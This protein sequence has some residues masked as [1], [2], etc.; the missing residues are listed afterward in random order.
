MRIHHHYKENTKEIPSRFELKNKIEKI[1]I[2][3]KNTQ[4][5]KRMDEC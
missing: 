2:K 5:A 3:I 1:K 4:H